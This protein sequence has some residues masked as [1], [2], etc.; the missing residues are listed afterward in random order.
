MPGCPIESFAG[1]LLAASDAERIDEKRGRLLFHQRDLALRGQRTTAGND[2]SGAGNVRQPA[3][4][5]LAAQPTL[6]AI[7][8]RKS[9]R[10]AGTA[11]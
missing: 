7:Y 3:R 10:D 11:G 9:H 6:R 5:R 4:L 2:G 1:N 8:S